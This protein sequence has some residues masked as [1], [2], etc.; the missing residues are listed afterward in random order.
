[1]NEKKTVSRERRLK[2]F[3]RTSE[4]ERQSK[5]RKTKAQKG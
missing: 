5:D 3:Q 4:K 2:S 1:M